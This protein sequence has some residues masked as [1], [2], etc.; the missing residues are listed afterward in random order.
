MI[1]IYHGIIVYSLLNNDITNDNKRLVLTFSKEKSNAIIAK[2]IKGPK[3]NNGYAELHELVILF[4]NIISLK[5]I[6]KK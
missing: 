1:D 6:L 5:I 3:A 4:M 2:F